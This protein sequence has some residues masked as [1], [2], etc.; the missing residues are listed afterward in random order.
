[1]QVAAE[2]ENKVSI[3]HTCCMCAASVNQSLASRIM[4]RSRAIQPSRR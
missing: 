4:P 3:E 2:Y 1:M